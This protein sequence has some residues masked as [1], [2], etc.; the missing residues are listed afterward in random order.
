MEVWRCGVEEMCRCGGGGVEV[1]RCGGV[2]LRRCVGVEVEVWR[3]GGVEMRRC[4]GVE[5]EVDQ[6]MVA[7]TLSLFTVTYW[8]V[9]LA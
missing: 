6:S 1:W 5:V 7:L 4:G 9:G 3:C 8:F 2:E